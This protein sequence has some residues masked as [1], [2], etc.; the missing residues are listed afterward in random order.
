MFCSLVM[1]RV[2]DKPIKL[3]DGSDALYSGQV[4]KRGQ[5]RGYG[6]RLITSK[7]QYK[8]RVDA[9][10]FANGTFQ[11]VGKRFTSDGHKLT[12]EFVKGCLDGVG[13]YEWPCGQRYSGQLKGG[14][15]H[16]FGTHTFGDGRVYIG[17]FVGDKQHGS[18]LF[19]YADGSKA[20]VMYENGQELSATK[21][22]IEDTRESSFHCV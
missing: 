10:M 4:N 16:G 15:S 20:A 5:P 21:G 2:A 7:D 13:L 14:K 18:A 8:G 12:G 9:G 6:E 19:V 17:W 22:C 3:T 1:S 11:G